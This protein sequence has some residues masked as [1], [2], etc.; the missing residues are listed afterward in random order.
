MR[1]MTVFAVGIER[2]DGTIRVGCPGQDNPKEYVDRVHFGWQ[3]DRDANL[4]DYD[5]AFDEITSS[6]G[7]LF[8]VL[9]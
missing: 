4:E 5:L 9:V 3:Y 7:R 1:R 6:H 8:Q 2:P